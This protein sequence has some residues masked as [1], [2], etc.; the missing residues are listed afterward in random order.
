MSDCEQ[1]MLEADSCVLREFHRGPQRFALIPF[2]SERPRWS[3]KRCGDCNVKHG[4]YHHLGCD[5]A[6]CPACRGQQITCGC[7][8]DEWGDDYDA[9][10]DD[11]D[12]L[13]EEQRIQRA[14]DA[15][16]AWTEWRSFD[17]PPEF[18]LV[19]GARRDAQEA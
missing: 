11:G 19:R 4:G 17:R 1:D 6:R 7:V 9:E 16:V 14:V 5:V 18:S 8:F 2:G 13:T 3:G 15:A 10:D 12:L